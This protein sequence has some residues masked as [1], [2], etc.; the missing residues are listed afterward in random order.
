VPAGE[1]SAV[2]VHEEPPSEVE[3]KSELSDPEAFVKTQSVALG[4]DNK[5]GSAPEGRVVTMLH[6]EPPSVVSMKALVPDPPWFATQ[7]FAVAHEI[8]P[9]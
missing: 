8:V 5:L 2:V 1:G 4:Q 7:T 3:T 9:P 6:V